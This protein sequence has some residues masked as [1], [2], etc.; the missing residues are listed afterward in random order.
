MYM[1][2]T[3]GKTGLGNN[4]IYQYIISISIIYY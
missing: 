1:A 4:T 2:S 3:W